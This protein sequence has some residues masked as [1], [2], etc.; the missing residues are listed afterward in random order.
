VKLVDQ[1]ADLP[2]HLV[3]EEVLQISDLQNQPVAKVMPMFRAVA[4]DSSVSLHSFTNVFR[5]HFVKK[6]VSNIEVRTAAELPAAASGGVK[7]G[8]AHTVVAFG[9]CSPGSAHSC[10]S[11]SQD[12]RIAVLLARLYHTFDR[13][14]DGNVDM[15]ELLTGIALLCGGSLV[16]KAAATFEFFDKDGGTFTCSALACL[17]CG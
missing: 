9:A 13:D 12:Q 2:A 17:Q 15:G 14:D 1:T 16:D 10:S 5:E 7:G 3:V 4:E 8:V 6:H 11:L